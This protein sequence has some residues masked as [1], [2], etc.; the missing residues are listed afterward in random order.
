MEVENGVVRVEVVGALD[1]LQHEQDLVA[2]DEDFEGEEVRHDLAGGECLQR[3]EEVTRHLQR[4][5]R[6]PGNRV[7]A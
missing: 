4:V 6:L 5:R 3:A 7:K 1:G 2:S